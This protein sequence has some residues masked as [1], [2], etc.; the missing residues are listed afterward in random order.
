MFDTGNRSA[1]T[2][3]AKTRLVRR[4]RLTTRLAHWSWATCLFFLLLSGLQ[5]FNAHPILHLGEESGFKYDNAVLD[6]GMEERNGAIRGVTVVLGHAFDTTGVLGISGVVDDRRVVAFPSWATI[7][8]YRDLATGRVF[9][10][11]FAWVFAA[12]LA[13]WALASVLNGHLARDLL[14]RWSDAASLPRDIL[15]HLMM[16]FHAGVRYT[17]LQKLTYAAVLF[18]LFPL[19]IAT[20]LCMSPGANAVFPWLTTLFGG[21]QTART[22]HFVVMAL[23]V[24]F[25]IVHIA[26]VILSGPLNEMRAILTGYYRVASRRSSR[27]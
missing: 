27:S 16:R 1:R 22:I 12:T 21:R 20:G 15:N 5:I 8:S 23:L 13:I 25:F 18:V 7:P 26:M 4:H 11:F 9:H 10:F 24:L 3:R 2:P 14:P 19:I 6:I 17:P